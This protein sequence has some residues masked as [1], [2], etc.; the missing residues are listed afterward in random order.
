MNKI[1]NKLLL[2]GE[3]FIPELHLKQQE[4]TSSAC[5]LFIKHRQ[6]I[7]NFRET[8][9]LKHLYRNEL[10]KTCFGQDPAY[11]NNKDFVKRTISEKILKDRAYE[12]ARNRKYDGYQRALASMIYK[13]F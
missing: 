12:V 10:E 2:T 11:S 3:K 9:N 13:F 4:F 8:G 6:R 5:G 7:Q 1:I